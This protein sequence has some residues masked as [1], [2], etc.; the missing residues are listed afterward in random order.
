MSLK[1]K[2]AVVGIGATEF[3]KC[4]GRTELQLAVEAVTGALADCNI[5]PS[6][7]DGIVTASHDRVTDA[8]V[9]RAIGS[10]SIAYSTQDQHG[11]G[12]ACALITQAALAIEA[13]LAETV[14]VYR[15]LNE[16]SEYRFG[17][18]SV[19]EHAEPSAVN[20]LTEFH[21]IHGLKTPAAIFGMFMRRYM[22]ET[23]A[24][25]ED[26]AKIAV[27]AR[28]YASTNPK[29][30]YYQRPLSTEEYFRSKMIV[31]PFRRPDICQESDGCVALVLVSAERAKDVGPAP[32]Y[33]RAATQAGTAGGVPIFNYYG[34]DITTRAQGALL[35]RRLY[36]QADIGPSDIDVAIIYDH[37]GPL[38][39]PALEA[40]G[41]CK[42]GEAKD[43]ISGNT[44]SVNGALPINPHGGLV[45]EAYIHGLNGI[46]EGVRQIRGTAA[47]QVVGVNH[48]LV[49]SAIGY[50]TSGMILG[51]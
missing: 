48:V 6:A 23:G 16:R 27:S 24:G 33:I 21:T 37:F 11:G 29:A 43:F 44:M 38:I 30:F 47:N 45:G 31:D 18:G 39:L 51:R 20:V 41:F 2:V 49:S 19:F 7:V 12:G 34:E 9:F 8:E 22:H 36:D 28:D 46:A 17:S 13:G 50:A 25:A 10:R 3:S 32:A 35:A 5:E 15:A 40:F 1:N 4:S 14:V 26:F 42:Y